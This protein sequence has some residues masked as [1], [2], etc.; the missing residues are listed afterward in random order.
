ML[1]VRRRRRPEFG[2]EVEF[3]QLDAS[4]LLPFDD[5]AS[6]TVTAAGMLQMQGFISADGILQQFLVGEEAAFFGQQLGN[7]QYAGI[8]SG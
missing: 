3:V 7:R 1:P 2:V 5:L 6:I 8:G 4:L